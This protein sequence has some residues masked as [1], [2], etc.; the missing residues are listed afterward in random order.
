M[1]SRSS[2]AI[3]VIAFH[4]TPARSGPTNRPPP[5]VWQAKQVV[6]KTCSPGSC[7]QTFL[8]VTSEDQDGKN[9]HDKGA[10]TLERNASHLSPALR[11]RSKRE[12]K[13]IL[14]ETIR[15]PEN[16]EIRIVRY[17]F[18]CIKVA[19]GFNLL[20]WR[21]PPTCAWRIP[22]RQGPSR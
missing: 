3:P 9:P 2:Q 1:I 11:C 17:R 5:I 20:L 10:F 16:R 14:D 13:I 21:I 12:L 4:V 6:L 22:V 18:Y 7:A 15:M 19:G 8:E